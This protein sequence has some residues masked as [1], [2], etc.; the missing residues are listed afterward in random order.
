MDRITTIVACNNYIRKLNLLGCA[1]NLVN[2]ILI[3]NQ[4]SDQKE[5]NQ[6][7][8]CK[9][10]TRLVLINN[11]VTDVSIYRYDTIWNVPNLQALDFQ[12]V[13]P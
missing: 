5:V 2:L 12:S 10:L 9:R 6:L 8:Q 1:P 11:P 13:L 7:R 4:I 3:G